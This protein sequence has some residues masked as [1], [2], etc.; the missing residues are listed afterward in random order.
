[1]PIR[2]SQRERYPPNWREISDRIRF[3]RAGSRCECTGQCDNEHPGGRCDAPHNALI[4]RHNDTPALWRTT[5]DLCE[6]LNEYGDQGIGYGDKQVR[7]ILTVAH[8]DHTPENVDDGNLLAM[9]QRCHLRYDRHEHTAN[10]RATRHRKAGQL[11]LFVEG[12]G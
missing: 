2:P 12:G 10:A 6:S 4:I 8:L 11:G 3:E 1:M 7:V 9:C 5:T